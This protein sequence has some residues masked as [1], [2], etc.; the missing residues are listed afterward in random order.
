[1]CLNSHYLLL[2]YI[3][4]KKKRYAIDKAKDIKIKKKNIGD[5]IFD[6]NVL[7]SLFNLI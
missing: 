2:C 1:M 4:N 7:W 3:K 6:K 5:K